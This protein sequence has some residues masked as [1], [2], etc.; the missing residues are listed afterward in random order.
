MDTLPFHHSICLTITQTWLAAC[1]LCSGG[2][3]S[4]PRSASPALGRQ[5]AC[6][7]DCDRTQGAQQGGRAQREPRTAVALGMGDDSSACHPLND[8]SCTCCRTDR[9]DAEPRTRL[10]DG[11]HV[12]FLARGQFSGLPILLY[13]PHLQDGAFTLQHR[14]PVPGLRA[15]RVQLGRITLHCPRLSSTALTAAIAQASRAR[16]RHGSARWAA[17]KSHAQLLLKRHKLERAVL[18]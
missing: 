11:P 9:A 2:G 18:D 3:Q 16:A 12:Q 15:H 10:P 7:G 5:K 17:K 4:V 13:L 14:R 1:G 6:H 8:C